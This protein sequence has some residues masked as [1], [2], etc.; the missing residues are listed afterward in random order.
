MCNMDMIMIM[1][2]EPQNLRSHLPHHP[3]ALLPPRAPT[4]K[5]KPFK[6]QEE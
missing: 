2:Y 3:H 4:H 5:E 1:I 6:T